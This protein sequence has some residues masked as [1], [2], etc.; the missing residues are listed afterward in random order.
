MTKIIKECE[1]H[2]AVEHKWMNKGENY[3]MHYVCTKCDRNRGDQD[4][5]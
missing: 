2:G 1:I 5:K 3:N 4:E